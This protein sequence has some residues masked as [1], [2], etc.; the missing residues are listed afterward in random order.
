[1]S[2]VRILVV[3]DELIIAEDIRMMLTNLGYDVVGTAIDYEEAMVILE[4]RQ[5]DVALVDILIAGDKD[6]IELAGIIK[7]RFNMPVIFITSHADKD[8]VERAKQVRPDGYLVKP[9]EQKDLYTSIEIAFSNFI[10]TD[11]KD[12]EKE[13]EEENNFVLKDSIFIRKDYL[14][15]KI[16]F[17]ELL[18]IKSE[19]NYIELQCKEKRHLVRS[20]LKN[21][22]KKLPPEKFIQVHKSYSINLD[23]ITIIDHRKICIN[24]MDIPI[25]RAYI[26]EVK[27]KLNIEL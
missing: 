1:M 16:R 20:S 24:E 21:F 15:V 10:K 25:G 2:K 12:V 8:T 17:D 4:H 27:K 3:E 19:G 22:L 26:D 7:E 6:G 9:F 23:Y 18:W 13:S 14:L 11:N 5:P